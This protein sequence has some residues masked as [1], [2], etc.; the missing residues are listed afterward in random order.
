MMVRLAGNYRGPS[1]ETINQQLGPDFYIWTAANFTV[2]A[3]ATYTI[4]KHLKAFVELN[5]LSNEPVKTYM[6]DSRRLTMSEW[7]GRRGQAGIRWDII[8]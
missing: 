6:G 8:R 2:D 7:Y 5:N 3:S 4:N 1:V